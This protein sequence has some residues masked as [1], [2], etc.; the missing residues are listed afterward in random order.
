MGFFEIA[1]IEVELIMDAAA[2]KHQIHHR[3]NVLSTLRRK[4]EERQKAKR[5]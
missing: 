4:L 5:D 3:A 1:L 2:S